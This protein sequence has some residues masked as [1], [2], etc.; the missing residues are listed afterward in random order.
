LNGRDGHARTEVLHGIR[1][2]RFE[3]LLEHGWGALTLHARRVWYRS[4]SFASRNLMVDFEGAT[5]GFE[6]K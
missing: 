2:M 5:D 4:R 6:T 3:C 1:E